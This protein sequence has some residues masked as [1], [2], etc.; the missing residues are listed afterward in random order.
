[1]TE[2]LSVSMDIYPFLTRFYTE[3]QAAFWSDSV[4]MCCTGF[5]AYELKQTVGLIF[6]NTIAVDINSTALLAATE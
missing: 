6:R 4:Q 5:K 2:F 3:Y 1:M